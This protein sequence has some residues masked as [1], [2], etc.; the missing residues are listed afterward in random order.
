MI[1]LQPDVIVAKFSSNE[2]FTSMI[3]T[4]E[5]SNYEPRAP[6]E[7][8]KQP[9]KSNNLRPQDLVTRQYLDWAS[10]SSW[11]AFLLGSLIYRKRQ[12]KDNK[13]GDLETRTKYT[14]PGWLSRR[15]LDLRVYSLGGWQ[16]NLRTYRALSPTH[17]FFTYA[18][19]GDVDGL[20]NMMLTR[21]ALASDRDSEHGLTALHVNVNQNLIM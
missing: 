15:A 7:T 6:S 16:A 8:K 4:S 20:R 12:L 13:T 2:T 11:V 14:L 5:G 3:T 1:R 9:T 19:R 17:D 18:V 10:S 21:Q